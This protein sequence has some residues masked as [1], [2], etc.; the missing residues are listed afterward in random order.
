[1]IDLTANRILGALPDSTLASIAPRLTVR[2]FAADY[3][4]QSADD[5]IQECYFPLRGMASILVTEASGKAVDTAIVGTEGFVGL[6]IFL[7]TDSMPADAMCQL[8]MTAAVI[9]A[10][11]LRLSLAEHPP[12]GA[13]LQRYT[14]MVLM[15]LARLV[16]CNRVHDLQDRAARWLLQVHD[17]VGMETPATLTHDFLADML[18]SHR[19]SVTLVL[20]RL[21][22][23]GLLETTRGTIAIPDPEGLEAVACDCYRTIRDELDRLIR[24]EG[25]D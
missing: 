15:E 17:R 18:G 22:A 24:R 5:P 8:D 2:S 6:P 14:Q 10:D 12:L 3:V 7:N 25:A 13:M 21:E 16:L 19:P 4:L 1:M 11:D 20:Q 23:Q 9:S